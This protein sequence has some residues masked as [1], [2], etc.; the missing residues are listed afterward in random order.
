M[1]QKVLKNVLVIGSKNARMEIAHKIGAVHI[2]WDCCVIV[3]I[4]ICTPTHSSSS[5]VREVESSH[6]RKLKH[7]FTCAFLYGHVLGLLA[8]RPPS[9]LSMCMKKAFG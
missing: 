4:L 9:A 7:V 5:T 8:W 3:E 2:D 1:V 6:V